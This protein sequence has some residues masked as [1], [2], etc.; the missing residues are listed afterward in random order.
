MA[1]K[2]T[3]KAKKSKLAKSKADPKSK[4]WRNK[5]DKA[6]SLYIR[7]RHKCLICGT[8]EYVQAHHLIDRWILPTRHHPLNGVPLCPKHH[9]WNRKISGHKSPYGI[10][11]MLRKSYPK[12]WEWLMAQFERWDEMVAEPVNYQE[13][14]LRLEELLK[15]LE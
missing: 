2:T 6:W 1:Q 12:Q 9:K 4:Y 10:A 15:T 13:T 3:K 5:A 8:E 11:W 7:R 14:Y